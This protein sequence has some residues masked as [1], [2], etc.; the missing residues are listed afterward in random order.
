MLNEIFMN[1]KNRKVP[2]LLHL[3]MVDFNNAKLFHNE[4]LDSCCH[5][6]VSK[7]LKK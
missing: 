1:K 5:K 7:Y 6:R 3:N 2:Q 4:L